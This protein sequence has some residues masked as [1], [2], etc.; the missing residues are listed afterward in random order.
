MKP[1]AAAAA[2]TACALPGAASAQEVFAG[3]YAHEV[4]TPFTLHVGESGADIAVGYRFAPIE[5][6]AAG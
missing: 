5:A 2:L 6:L 4:D 3:V 1:R